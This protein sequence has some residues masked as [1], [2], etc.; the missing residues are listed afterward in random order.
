M[1]A[2]TTRRLRLVPV[3]LE[4]IEGVLLHDRARAEAA[5]EDIA[6][7]CGSQHQGR[8]QFPPAWPNDE[9]V[10]IGFPYSL[11]AIRASPQ[12]RLWGDSLVLPLEGP[13]IVLGS[14]VFKG[15]PADGVAEVGYAV[16]ESSRSQGYATEATQACVEWALAQDGITAIQATTFPWHHASLG[17]IRKC[18]MTQ[19]G[20]REHEML[21]DLLVFE[22]RRPT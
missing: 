19:I 21:G 5:L 10:S 16:V 4:A 12:T 18:G 14:V 8:A 1:P 22:R 3:T 11:D 15:H 7:V 9:L 13:A 17:V 2:L 6:R 20:T